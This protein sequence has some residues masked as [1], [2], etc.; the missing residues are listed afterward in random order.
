MIEGMKA[1]LV[2]CTRGVSIAC[3]SAIAGAC[4]GRPCLSSVVHSG[5]R[6]WLCVVLGASVAP[7]QSAML[8]AAPSAS[9]KI[10]HGAAA[11][12]RGEAAA[13]VE[14]FTKALAD[15]A[16]DK[17]RR[18]TILNDRGVAFSKLGQ[19][20]NA[21]NDF[22]RAV[23]LF[24]EYAGIY[25]NRGNL[26][27]SL[28]LYKEAL[29][30][31]DRA[32]VLAPGYAAAYNNR[33][34]TRLRLGDSSGAILDYTRAIKLQPTNAAPLSG[35]GR[36]HFNL[37]RPHAAIRDFS[38][39][40]TADARFASGYRNRAE[41]KLE[42]GHYAEAIEDLSRAVAFDV[43]NAE[44]YLLRG[45]SY[46]AT[47]EIPAAIVD[48]SKVIELWPSSS[49][50]YEARGLAYVMSDGLDEAFVDLNQAI[51]LNPRSETAFA[52]RAYAYSRSDQTDVG[53]RDI[54]TALKLNP[55]SAEVYWARAQLREAL[56][57]TDLAIGD[58]REALQLKPNFK[59]AR[60]SLIRLGDG[61][62]QIGDKLVK[63][64][65]IEGWDVVQR[66]GRYYAVM[67]GKVRIRVPLEMMGKG[68]PK[69]LEWTVQP[70]PFKDIG[71]L[72]FFCGKVAGENGPE[73]V[74][75][76]AIIDIRRATVVAI[77]P[78]RQ[79]KQVANWTWEN[80]NVTVASADGVTDQF[81]LRALKPKVTR[82]YKP[83]RRKTRRK[84]KTLFEL[85]FSN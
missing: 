68:A 51:T 58:L 36:A 1:L 44:I 20:Q 11:L 55:K 73:P 84:P 2:A 30:D 4:R 66:D 28:G 74:E 6:L 69:L 62:E 21:I 15:P 34:V 81:A 40:V 10:Q 72:R 75:H 76:A 63:G 17:D 9:V 77:Q 78:H 83:K 22:N 29:K 70:E 59:R 82:A 38:R 61:D 25:N 43:N 39:A 47:G 60:D 71:V 7:L 14:H 53:M 67:D 33:A 45:H 8:A 85:L 56:G 18:A 31:F 80:G 24:P 46:L 26:L 48:F 52:F 37:G 23:K 54:E 12:V 5:G 19:T 41:A 42:V 35:R 49:I 13:A 64:R 65:G 16:L 27:L 57:Q 32:L 50:G 79:G 3:R